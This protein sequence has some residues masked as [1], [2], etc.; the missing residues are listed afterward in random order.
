MKKELIAVSCIILILSMPLA[1]AQEFKP[2][3]SPVEFEEREA[4]EAITVIAKSYEPKTL[5][6]SAIEQDNVPVF[7]Y[8]AGSSLGSITAPELVTEGRMTVVK[9]GDIFYGVPPIKNVFIKE[10]DYERG[11]IRS[12]TYK[13]PKNRL[14]SMDNLGYLIVNLVKIPKEK[15]VPDVIDVNLTARIEF[16]MER[17]YGIGRQTLVLGE[18]A[19]EQSFLK[20]SDLRNN[21]VFSGYSYVR[22]VKIYEN[23]ADFIVYDTALKSLGS[24]TNVKVNEISSPITLRDTHGNLIQTRFRLQVDSVVDP[25]RSYAEAEVSI[26]GSMPEKKILYKGSTLYPGSSIQVSDISKT[27]FGKETTEAVKFTGPAGVSI[28]S[29]KYNDL[30][31]VLDAEIKDKTLLSAA[32]K[33]KAGMPISDLFKEGNFNF[34][35][36]KKLIPG[37]PS[38]VIDAKDITFD[39]DYPPATFIGKVVA[40]KDVLADLRLSPSIESSV[41]E[42]KETI[43]IKL[44]KEK[45]RNVVDVCSAGDL[46]F[47]KDAYFNQAVKNNFDY[48]FR[49][50]EVFSTYEKKRMLCSSIDVL[51]KVSSSYADEFEDNFTYSSKADYL[52]AKNYEE[53]ALLK[54][55]V[56]PSIAKSNALTYYRRS[57]SA[58]FQA[59]DLQ[60]RINALGVSFVTGEG[61]SDV[62]FDDNGRDVSVHLLQVVEGKGNQVGSTAR[63]SVNSKPAKILRVGESLFPGESRDMDQ[64][65]VKDILSTSVVIE[66]CP[67]HDKDGKTIG[68]SPDITLKENVAVAI[69]NYKAMLQDTELN[70]QVLVTV[71]PGS[72]KSFFSESSFLLHI[73]VEKRAIELSTDKIDDKIKD[74][75]EQI[76]KLNEVI[77]KLDKII[78]SWKTVCLVTF[79]YLTIKNSF[80]VFGGGA[81]RVKAREKVMVDSGWR[82]YCELE[83]GPGKTYKSYDDCV[84]EHA[85]KIDKDI[86]AVQQ[87]LESA[88]SKYKKGTDNIDGVDVKNIREFGKFSGSDLY[89]EEQYMDLLYCKE[90]SQSCQST[91]GSD[92]KVDADSKG[93]NLPTTCAGVSAKC[94]DKLFEFEQMNKNTGA[95]LDKLKESKLDSWTAYD[96]NCKDS[97]KVCTL[98][99]FN[100]ERS[101]MVS[102]QLSLARFD[103]YFA[104]EL[105]L[106]QSNNKPLPADIIEVVVDKNCKEPLAVEPE[107]PKCIPSK[108]YW[109]TAQGT[110]EV[111]KVVR[112]GKTA[113]SYKDLVLEGVKPADKK[114]TV[115][116]IVWNADKKKGT[117][118][119]PDGSYPVHAGSKGE[120]LFDDTTVFSGYQAVTHSELTLGDVAGTRQT[121]DSG[122]TYECYDDAKPYCVPLSNGNFV[123]VLEFYKDGSAKTMNIWN[124]GSDGRLCTSD[125]VPAAGDPKYS[126]CAHTSSLMTNKDCSRVL[127][128]VQSRV[129]AAFRY[130]KS[131]SVF[132]SSDGHKF[133]YS[134]A[135]AGQDYYSKAGHCEDAMEIDDCKTMFAVCDPVM[136]PP[137][138]FNLAGNWQVDDVAKT[139]I[140]GSL[141]LGLPNF[142]TTPVPVCLTGVSAGLKNIRSVF[143][144]YKSCLVTMKVEGKSVGIC[145]KIRSVYICQIL[146]QEAIAIFRVKGGLLD[147]IAKMFGNIGGGGEY[148]SFSDNFANIEKSVNYFTQ[149]YASSVFAAAKGRSLE[150]IGTEVCKSAVNGKLPYLGEYFDHLTEPENPPQFTAI[151]DEFPN[152]EMPYS[153]TRRL[154]Q[155]SVYYHIYAGTDQELQYSVYLKS[156]DNRRFYVTEKCDQRSRQ[157]AKG[158]FAD[159]SLTCVTATGYTMIC[160]DI[161]GKESCGF[162]KVSTA[163]SLNYLNDMVVKDESQRQITK[164]EDCVPDYPRTSPSLGSVALP[165][166]I[167]L[168][169]TGVVRVCSFDNPGKGVNSKGW[170]QVGTCLDKDGKSWGSCWMDLSTVDVKYVSDRS[171]LEK[172]LEKRGISL[173]ANKKGVPE[174]ALLKADASGAKISD[175]AALMGSKTWPDYIKA[176]AALQ[177]VVDLS[178]DP[179]SIAKALY[180]IGDIYYKMATTTPTAAE[181]EKSK[182][183]EASTT[184]IIKESEVKREDNCYDGNDNDIDGSIDCLDDDCEDKPCYYEVGDPVASMLS[185]KCHDRKCVQCVPGANAPCCD[186]YTSTFKPSNVECG[187]KKWYECVTISNKP[188]LFMTLTKTYCSGTSEI[189]SG[190]EEAG[191]PTFIKS[192][193]GSLPVC[194][195]EGC[196]TG[197]YPVCDAK[198]GG[199]SSSLQASTPTTSAQVIDQLKSV[200]TDTSAPEKRIAADTASKVI[201]QRYASQQS[202]TYCDAVRTLYSEAESTFAN[203]DAEAANYVGL[204]FLVSQR[205]GVCSI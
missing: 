85:D 178:V 150:E 94:Q 110:V 97:K 152:P 11:I 173:D 186:P 166:Q 5:V 58:G 151:F 104:R 6:A 47:S 24:R 59:E 155:Y 140:I 116:T 56:N 183:V 121:Y 197:K 182:K 135:S 117:A 144:A 74:T 108:Y 105:K 78:K 13:P 99:D 1:F 205:R 131:K 18:E 145:D 23:S 203:L 36:I 40:F 136:C 21:M 92:V 66:N 90:L 60:G 170:Q 14:Y 122:A 188:S 184:N 125:D 189:C 68:T 43:T 93:K 129:N 28:A 168:L 175:A 171:A 134:T 10:S 159:F 4:G 34:D 174:S 195:A 146:W 67:R 17:T 83:S 192:C 185:K 112:D 57:Q 2:L 194:D 80:G 20:K 91:Y 84:F 32:F 167:S 111:N 119:T 204:N 52:I 106:Y 62:V 98:A 61:S 196:N 198:E 73:P 103:A 48:F 86:D 149:S 12:V 64:C 22:A 69:E 127:S 143:E 137:S 15:D 100:N 114:V 177:E 154:S 158:S 156:P 9:Q 165:G 89:S 71:L 26:D 180:Y 33:Y 141:V 132:S 163:F 35:G 164:V 109:E 176:L 38:I 200:P 202:I 81:S 53:L 161:N 199:C 142:P 75:E 30:S 107:L 50:D 46:V 187:E 3:P 124:V 44:F 77:G 179:K 102:E 128:E 39:K 41:A 115:S 191:F 79:A 148:L 45:D 172:E 31:K 157:V 27:S 54:D 88:N 162:G 139:G 113:Y 133:K 160:V 63:I 7:V 70:K 29:R 120:A 96:K 25:Q 95:A 19:N 51:K 147:I 169:R 8:L 65:R 123:K 101:A 49:D 55:V 42:G 72:G 201:I 153:E 130:C 181:V 138:R 82:K 126:V 76:K 190:N 87:A 16:D 37:D 118:K 193:S